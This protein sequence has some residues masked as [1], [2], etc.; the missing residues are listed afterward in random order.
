[1]LAILEKSGPRSLKVGTNLFGRFTLLKGEELKRE[2]E[3]GNPES[4]ITFL[5]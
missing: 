3:D 1:M 4:S 2:A 5:Q